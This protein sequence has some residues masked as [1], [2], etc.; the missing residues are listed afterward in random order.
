MDGRRWRFVIL[1][2]ILAS[3]GC[4]H[5]TNGLP[6]ANPTYLDYFPGPEPAGGAGPEP[7]PA[8]PE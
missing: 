7:T 6:M 2:A 3:G 5:W 4:Q 8:A 1:F